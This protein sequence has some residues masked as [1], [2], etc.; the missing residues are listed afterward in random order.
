MKTLKFKNVLL[1]S[2]AATSDESKI[3]T[4][5]H[6]SCGGQTLNCVWHE[7]RIEHESTFS[8]N[9]ATSI[10]R[11]KGVKEKITKRIFFY[12]SWI[13]ISDCII[14]VLTL[15]IGNVLSGLFWNYFLSVSVQRK[16][17]LRANALSWLATLFRRH[18]AWKLSKILCARCEGGFPS[19]PR[20]KLCLLLSEKKTVCERS[21]PSVDHC[22]WRARKFK[23]LCV[24]TLLYYDNNT[25]VTAEVF[26]SRHVKSTA[27][28][29]IPIFYSTLG[30]KSFYVHEVTLRSMSDQ[31]F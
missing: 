10:Y 16:V 21:V 28:V 7:P 2:I 4:Q 26:L 27:L 12:L 11:W 20:S 31:R 29:T 14:F 30:L 9:F 23:L 22:V 18:T 3:D 13:R 24:Y 19:S 6:A 5:R 15:K 25:K 1:C 17:V 8:F